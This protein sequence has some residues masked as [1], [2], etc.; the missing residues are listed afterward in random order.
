MTTSQEM[1]LRLKIQKLE[2]VLDIL[3]QEADRQITIFLPEK[4]E[5]QVSYLKKEI[6]TTVEMI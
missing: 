4:Y 3:C 1:T 2:Y 5:D 6:I